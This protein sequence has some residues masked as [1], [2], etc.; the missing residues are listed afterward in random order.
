[1]CV[2]EKTLDTIK[3]V[4]IQSNWEKEIG[5]NFVKTDGTS[6]MSGPLKF[7]AGSMRG[8]IAGGFNGVTFFKMDSQGDLMQIGSLSDSQFVPSSDN[9]L[10]IGTSV[11]KIERIYL[12]K[13]NNGYDID[14]PVTNSADTL[15]LKSQVDDAANSGEQ[16]YTTG[17]WYAKMYSATTVPT[18]AEYEGT[19]YADFSQV[20]Q[21]NDPIIVVYTYTDGAWVLTETIPTPKNHNG[22]MTIT[23]K[24][25]DIAEQAGQ[26]GGL[27]LWSHNQGT[28]TPYP[29]I[30]S[31]DS[32]S[33]TG[34]STVEMPANPGLTQIVN[35]NYVDNAVAAVTGVKTIDAD[36]VGSLTVSANGDVSGLSNTNYLIFPGTID[37]TNANTFEMVFAFTTSSN[38]AG[39]VII[40]GATSDQHSFHMGVL[41]SKIYVQVNDYPNSISMTA[42]TTLQTNT[43]YYAKLTYDGTDYTLYLSTD[44]VTWNTETSMTATYLIGN[45]AKPYKLGQKAYPNQGLQTLHLAE[46]YIKKD[47]CLIW[48][49]L[50]EP[51]LHQRAII[52]HEVIEFQAPTSSNNYTWY[53]KYR[54][55]WVEQG[56]TIVGDATTKTINLPITMADTNYQITV[57]Q[58]S[59]DTNNLTR[60]ASGISTKTIN[61]F[62]SYTPSGDSKDWVVY[63]MAA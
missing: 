49:G 30:V 26:Q 23:S 40:G 41:G 27:V 4:V 5:N 11:R 19:N 57:S 31:F 46:C 18:G 39:G 24:I 38:I 2:T 1:M 29:R 45:I 28:F 59:A 63:G 34:N 6:V 36:I 53:R 25:W 61:S 56:G 50:G 47:N 52:G 8:A 55:G 10:D 14:V 3:T 7:S 60:R 21:D 33:V 51:G 22:Y 58:I 48:V 12:G 62:D 43:K 20:D 13:V 37:M 44:G 17:V 42:T 54:D 9:T 35:K 16:L 32:I 15:A